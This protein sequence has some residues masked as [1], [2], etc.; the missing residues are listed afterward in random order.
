M[1]GS[2]HDPRRS[3]TSRIEAVVGAEGGRGVDERGGLDDVAFLDVAEEVLALDGV[4]E[5]G[6]ASVEEVLAGGREVRVEEEEEELRVG[7]VGVVLFAR[8]AERAVR[9]ER[10]RDGVG[11]L[12][13]V[14]GGLAVDGLGRRLGERD[15]ERDLGPRRRSFEVGAVARLHDEAVGAL[16]GH[17]VVELVLDEVDEVARRHGRR[18]AVDDHLDARLVEELAV[19]VELGLALLLGGRALLEHELDA[20]AAVE[21]RQIRVLGGHLRGVADGHE[22]RFHFRHERR[23]RRLRLDR[24]VQRFALLRRPRRP[25]VGERLADRLEALGVER[26]ELGVNFRGALLGRRRRDERRL[27]R[28]E[29]PLGRLD[30]ADRGADALGAQVVA[31]RLDRLL[32]LAHLL[33]ALDARQ[34]QPVPQQALGV[35][36]DAA[37]GRRRRVLRPRRHRRRGAVRQLRRRHRRTDDDRRSRDARRDPSSDHARRPGDEPRRRWR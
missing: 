21:P 35:L 15:L 27:R 7:R 3:G 26:R 25:D 18:V 2:C 34:R 11:A 29:Q 31:D 12:A 16:D 36:V 9:L 22:P 1:D 28:C 10:E 13:G 30:V 32:H 24:G 5:A 8:H 37:P 17:A 6:V 19:D 4:A 23:R 33:A 20:R 14:L